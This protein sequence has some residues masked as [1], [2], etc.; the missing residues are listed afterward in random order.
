MNL[1]VIH[2]VQSCNLDCYYCPMKKWMKP[3]DFV[4]PEDG[5]YPGETAGAKFNSLTNDT[6]LKW[7]DTY[8]PPKEW[9]L[10]LTGGEP[11][12]YPE[13]NSLIP[14]LS[15]RGYRGVITTN[16]TLPIPKDDNFIRVAAWH[17]CVHNLPPY[18]D[19]VLILEQNP[20]DDTDR[21][22]Q[23][24]TDHGI[25]FYASLWVPFH[26]KNRQPTPQWVFSDSQLDN[27]CFMYSMGQIVG[28]PKIP[29]T[30][31]LSIHKMTPPA[32]IPLKPNCPRCV[33][34]AVA[35]RFMPQEWLQGGSI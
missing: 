1:L 32:P 9:L 26:D 34:A 25:P 14:A 29:V 11:G 5:A 3:L 24:C 28:C 20:N 6:L 18:H 19:I 2:L 35:E 8:C 13:I 4:F 21:K 27:L 31:D 17:E 10:H 23:Y 16:G 7:L 33:H 30:A 22:K 12:L 15:S